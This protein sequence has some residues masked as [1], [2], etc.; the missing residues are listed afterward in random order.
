MAIYAVEIAYTNVVS[1]EADTEADA[2]ARVEG[3]DDLPLP[4]RGEIVA[5]ERMED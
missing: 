4:T 3:M 1:V 2:K 5:I